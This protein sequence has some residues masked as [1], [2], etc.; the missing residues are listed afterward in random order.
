[1]SLVLI[2]YYFGDE[3]GQGF[4]HE[5]AGIVLFLSALILIIGLDTLLRHF[6]KS[7][8]VKGTE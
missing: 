5:F 3:V 7:G 6:I 1:M 2:T 8:I 4:L